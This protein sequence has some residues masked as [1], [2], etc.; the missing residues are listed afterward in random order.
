MSATGG[1][2]SSRT[3]P[4][5]GITTS[6]E[7]DPT[8]DGRLRVHRD[9]RVSPTNRRCFRTISRN[10]RDRARAECG[11]HPLH[12]CL[13]RPGCCFGACP[14]TYGLIDGSS[15]SRGGRGS[16]PHLV[17]GGP[18]GRD[19][20]SGSTRA[21]GDA[22]EPTRDGA[23]H[24]RLDPDGDRTGPRAERMWPRLTARPAGGPPVPL[25]GAG[26]HRPA[27]IDAGYTDGGTPVPPRQHA[28]PARG[29]VARSDCATSVD[30]GQRY[31]RRANPDRGRRC[32]VGRRT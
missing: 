2:S 4:R 23:H 10:P 5:R 12:S 8:P 16:S 7:N 18:R 30:L 31:A 22:S 19:E 24:G 14:D 13:R 9:V 6:S 21:Q 1:D 29:P 17:K 11:I 15:S 27:R 3:P 28:R 32:D 20:E 25:A 26:A